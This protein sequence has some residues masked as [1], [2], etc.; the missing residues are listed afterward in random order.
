MLPEPLSSAILNVDN[1]NKK[2][3]MKKTPGYEFDFG[4]FDFNIEF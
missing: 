1:N 4:K 3:Y 2:K